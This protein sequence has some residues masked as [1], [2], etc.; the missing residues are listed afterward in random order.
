MS[1]SKTKFLCDSLKFLVS[2]LSETKLGL[3]EEME[4]G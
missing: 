2:I 3:F 4:T 1:K